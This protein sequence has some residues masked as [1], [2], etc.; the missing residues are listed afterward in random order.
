ME[1][2][3]FFL[4][5]A[6]GFL[7]D[8][9][10]AYGLAVFVGLPLWA[11]ATL[12]FL[13]AALANYTFHEVWTFRAAELNLSVLR[14]IKYLAVSLFTLLSRIIIVITLK[15]ALPDRVLLVLICAAAVSLLVNFVLSKF[16][17]FSN[18]NTGRTSS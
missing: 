6:L 1:M 14:S 8:I 7:I 18:S 13:I 4:V 9:S 15:T 11:A 12:G 2:V 16:V 3:R 17:V 5:S 10:I